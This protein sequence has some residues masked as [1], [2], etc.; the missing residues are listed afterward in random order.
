LLNLS[1][2]HKQFVE[3]ANVY[4]ENGVADLRD[5]RLTD[6]RAPCRTLDLLEPRF[7]KSQT[8]VITPFD[9]SVIL[10]S[11]LNCAEFSSRLSEVVQ[12][13]DAISG[14]QFLVAGSGVGEPW[15]LGSI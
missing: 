3:R 7:S 11:L 1:V 13:L 4:P 2:R 10:I 12:S 8:T 9:D 6:R 15:F 5:F 14:I